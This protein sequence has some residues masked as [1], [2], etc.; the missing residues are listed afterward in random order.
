[1]VYFNLRDARIKVLGR[2]SGPSR[3]VERANDP[4][5]ARAVLFGK[6]ISG[7]MIGYLAT[8]A[9]IST[10]YYPTFWIMMA[11]AVALRNT[12]ERY[13]AAEAVVIEERTNYAGP[14]L[15]RQRPAK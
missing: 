7:G 9:F 10:L 5:F 2:W 14:S 11:L 12:T 3:K 13:V 6:A 8:S 15:L 1:M 4:Q